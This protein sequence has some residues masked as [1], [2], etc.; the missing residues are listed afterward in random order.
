MPFSLE[1]EG[2]D[3]QVIGPFEK[4]SGL[5]QA[6]RLSAEILERAGYKVYRVDFDLD[7][8]APEGFNKT[9]KISKLPKKAKIN[10]IHLNAES[11]PL[12]IAY[13]PDVFTN[14][15]NIGYF[16]W[17]LDSPAKCHYL[18]M[19]LVDEIWV[20][21]EYGVKQYQPF[22]DKP[23]YKAGMAYE[24]VKTV[25]KEEAK[26]FLLNRYGIPE[27]K[28]VFLATF[29]SFSFIQRK[30]P[31]GVIKAFKK[32][33]PNKDDV[34]LVLKTHNRHRVFDPAQIKIWNAVDRYVSEDKRIILINETLTYED[35]MKLKKGADCYVSLH[36]SEGWGFGIVEAMNL[37]VPVIATAYSANLEVCNEENSWLVD[38][39]ETFLN[40]DDYIFVIP[41]QKWAEPKIESAA[42]AMREVYENKEL[43]EQKAKKA[44]EF[45]RKNF[46]IDAIAKRYKRRIEEI[47]KEVS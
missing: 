19:E 35:L 47:L 27:D 37:G 3:I 29:D 15:Y 8:P 14:A 26:K 12:A 30:N 13:M 41:G 5:G 9:S 33:F 39:E 10:L 16:F 7:N 20:A 43:R 11:I 36:R 2:Y 6:T 44:Q 21:S 31:L 24:D 22:T 38:Y 32:A 18:G 42:G 1:E 17:E 4:S 46:S 34:V 23:V 45:L 25:S 40:Q 28:F